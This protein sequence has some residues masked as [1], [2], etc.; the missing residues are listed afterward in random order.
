MPKLLLFAPCEKVIVDQQNNVSLIS[1]L[2]DLKIQVPETGPVPPANAS[3][4]I[5]WDVLTVWARS[6]DDAGKR[7]EQ[8]IAL[9]NPEGA[10]TEISTTTP[11]ETKNASHRIV[12]TI[13]GFP[14]GSSGRY[15]LKLWLSEDGRESREPI[16]EY[17]ITVSQEVL[18]K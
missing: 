9:F 4:A 7:Y 11:V 1:I 10:P 6:D 13:F 15:R 17:A 18:K 2:Q 14:I 12:A 16:A 8:R 3:A 5:K